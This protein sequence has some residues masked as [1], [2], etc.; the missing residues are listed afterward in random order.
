MLVQGGAT[1]E[2]TIEIFINAHHGRG[3]VL[4]WAE[5]TSR[6]VGKYMSVDKQRPH[7]N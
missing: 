4:I 2:L 7:I 3:H 6:W 1:D 5:D